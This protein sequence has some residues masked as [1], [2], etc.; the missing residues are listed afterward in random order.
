VS[1]AVAAE[2]ER[3][4]AFLAAHGVE[5]ARLEAEVLLADLLGADR[6]RLF[7]ERSVSAATA[8]RFAELLERRGRGEPLQHLRGRQEFFSREFAVDARV[9]IPRSETELL[10]E[11]ALRFVEPIERP[12][13]LDVGTGSGAVAITL[14]LER[15]DARVCASDASEAALEVARVNARR[16]GAERVE[17]RRGDLVEP[18]AAER[19]DLVVSNPPYVASA[20]I[21]ALAAEVR[22]HEPRLALDG[23]PD[24]L[25]AYRRLDACV[26]RVLAPGGILAV[27]I[28]FGQRD[29][30]CEILA[31][32]GRRLAAV[33]RDLAGIERV[34]V[35]RRG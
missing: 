19:F 30:V 26:D 31:R 5:A 24:G 6:A 23:G 21:E 8:A 10:V 2:L 11:T 1:V 17:L 28:G 32:G 14:A 25:D 20:E 22:V 15:P 34:V 29:A 35:V 3:A 4:T 13:I 9:L 27:E 7:V 18:F 33:E 12:A 16:L